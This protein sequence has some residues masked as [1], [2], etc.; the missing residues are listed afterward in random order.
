MPTSTPILPGSLLS[1][2]PWSLLLITT[3]AAA[4]TS[5]AGPAGA[6]SPSPLPY[7]SALSAYQAYTDEQVQPW[8]EANERVGRIGGWRTYAKEAARGTS[9]P[10]APVANPHAGQHQH[11]QP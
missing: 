11:A 7:T 3:A 8:R 9:A 1:W 10:Q 6:A 4:Q 5:A 2:W